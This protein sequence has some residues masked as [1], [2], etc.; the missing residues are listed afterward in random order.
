MNTREAAK[1]RIM[2][3]QKEDYNFLTYTLLIFLDTLKCTSEHTPLRDFR[4]VAYLVDF[5]NQGGDFTKYSPNQLSSIYSKA[6]IKKQLIHH[7]LH[8]L[9]NREYIGISRNNPHKSLDI[10][11]KK[12][13]IPEGFLDQ[14]LFK[15]EIDNIKILS[16][17]FPY[18][19]LK[20]ITT[21]DLSDVIYKSNNVITWDF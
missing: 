16:K 8:V 20:T 2:F 9:N 5:I 3:I 18:R 17:L 4:K 1:R 13:N 21:K 15:N 10:W 6:L 14:D 19:S 7:L 11:I 12:E